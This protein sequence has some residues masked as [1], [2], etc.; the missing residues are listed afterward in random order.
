[1]TS[2][3]LLVDDHAVLVRGLRELLSDHFPGMEFGHADSAAALTAE[4]DRGF[5][6]VVVLDLNLPGSP[7]LELLRQIKEAS[8]KSRVLIY[9]A[10]PESQFGVRAI[11]AGADGFIT[12]DRPVEEFIVAVRKVLDGRRYVSD[13]LLEK[14]ADTLSQPDAHLGHE[15]LSNREMHVLRSLAAGKSPSEIAAELGISI[16][17]VSTYRS[18]ILE[19]LQLETTADIIRYALE[20]G[21]TS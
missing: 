2:R 8:P 11:R 12:K 21:L 15:S 10:H 9:T 7:G 6:N 17:T 4:L 1:V 13:T 3:L 18:R 5:W 14:L 16:K 20:H 19:K